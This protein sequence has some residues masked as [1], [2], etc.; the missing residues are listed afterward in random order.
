M[1]LNRHLDG[2]DATEGD[3]V[4]LRMH[5]FRPK[6]YPLGPSLSLMPTILSFKFIRNA[7]F[8]EVDHP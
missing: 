7:A 3:G 5:H 4:N 6:D 1:N 8:I 2:V